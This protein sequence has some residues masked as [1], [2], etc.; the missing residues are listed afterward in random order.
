MFEMFEDDIRRDWIR[1]ACAP[2]ITTNAILWLE[3]NNIVGRWW[4]PN[5][6]SQ[7]SIM[8]QWVIWLE[9]E[10]DATLYKLTWL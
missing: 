1:I 10:E 2:E 5:P 6:P 7:H 3:S 8:Y 9:L 4:F